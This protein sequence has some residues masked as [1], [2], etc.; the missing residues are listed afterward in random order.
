MRP[1]ETMLVAGAGLGGATAKWCHGSGKCDPALAKVGESIVEAVLPS[2]CRAPCSLRM[3]TKYGTASVDVNGPEVTWSRVVDNIGGGGPGANMGRFLRVF[4]R[5]LAWETNGI[6]C[7]S[8]AQPHAIEST[9][10]KLMVF[11]SPHTAMRLV[12][13]RHLC[14]LPLSLVDPKR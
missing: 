9:V 6:A 3:T 12:M 4:G 7:V 13:R 10:L 5:G 1:N 2:N 8:A 14:F 11:L